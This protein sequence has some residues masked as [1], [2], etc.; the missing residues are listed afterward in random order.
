MQVDTNEKNTAIISGKIAKE[1][2]FSHE[3]YGEGFYV[4]YVNIPR[5]SGSFDEL[6]V[7]ISERLE[8]PNQIKEGKNV[9]IEGQ[10]RSHNDPNG[11]KTKLRLMVFARDYKEISEEKA[12]ESNNIIVL[13]GFICKEP[14]YRMTPFKREITDILLAV[15]RSYNKSDYIPCICWGRNARFCGKCKVGQ[16]VKVTGRIQSRKYNKKFPDGTEKEMIAYE[17]S[18]ANLEIIDDKNQEKTENE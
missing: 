4:F 10:Y 7:M 3:L 15:N 6:P 18:I 9:C 13:D 8:D 2:V 17:V 5:T 1:P 16:N 11:N 14:I 12:P